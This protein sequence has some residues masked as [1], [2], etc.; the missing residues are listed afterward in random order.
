MHRRGGTF[1]DHARDG[2]DRL[3]PQTHP[4]DRHPAAQTIKDRLA[5]AGLIRCAG[6]WRDDQMGG[7]E[8]VRLLGVYLVVA[9]HVNGY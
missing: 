3:M 6:P 8:T 7:C 2:T 1:D 4:E 9:H 5:G